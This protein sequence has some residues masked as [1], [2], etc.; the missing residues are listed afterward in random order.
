MSGIVTTTF[1]I[2]GAGGA[3]TTVAALAGQCR[4]ESANRIAMVRG[5][6]MEDVRAI[7]G[8]NDA[9]AAS[10]AFF[11]RRVLGAEVG[12]H[13]IGTCEASYYREDRVR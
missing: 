8:I 3:P 12:V 1:T 6:S 5:T 11:F 13:S 2:T 7:M 10:A 9:K 4:V